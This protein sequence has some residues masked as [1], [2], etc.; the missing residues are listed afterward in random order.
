MNSKVNTLCAF[1]GGVAVGALTMF[2]I[3]KKLGYERPS[4]AAEGEDASEEDAPKPHIAKRP[5]KEEELPQTKRDV[6]SFS[7][8]EKLDTQR[9]QYHVPDKP[10]LDVVSAK[11]E[12]KDYDQHMAEREHPEDDE[13]DDE[14]DE[15]DEEKLLQQ[16]I[17]EALMDHPGEMEDGDRSY[18]TDGYGHILMKL[19]CDKKDVEIYLVHADYG[20]EIYPLEDLR[21]F[22][23]DGVL[24]DVLDSPVNDIDRTVGSALEHF[25]ECGAGPDSVFVRNI[26][27]GFE[28]EIIRETGSFAAYIYGVT[29]EES[30]LPTRPGAHPSK[31]RKQKRDKE[32]EED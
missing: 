23:R 15:E 4:D 28:Y 25:G 3:M 20:G 31:M 29:D 16:E 32:D 21:Y 7:L 27:T 10:D 13:P 12:N 6:P 26:S 1:L 22:E 14:E 24:C 2:G 5:K 17:A 9:I 18:D 11:Y 30:A 19:S 8:P